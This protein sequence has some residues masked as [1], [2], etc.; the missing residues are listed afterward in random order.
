MHNKKYT[1]YSRVITALTSIGKDPKNVGGCNLL[2]PLGD[3]EKTTWQGINGA[4]SVSY[5]H[6]DV[7]ERQFQGY[8]CIFKAYF[9]VCV[10]LL[11]T[12][13]SARVIV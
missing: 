3:F 8:V 9:F 13:P 10:Y 7:Y 12:V 4:I 11:K 5:T 2:L 6:L 1:E